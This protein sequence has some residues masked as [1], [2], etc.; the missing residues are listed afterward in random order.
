MNVANSAMNLLLYSRVIKETPEYEA[1]AMEHM[2][3]LLGRNPLSV[4]YITGFGTHAAKKPHHRPS[5]A[6]GSAFA[7]MVV[8]GP[9]ANT[10]RD[11]TL[12]SHCEGSPPSKFY[13][14][15]KDSFASNEVAIYWN[16]VVFFV[17]SVLGM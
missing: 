10:P 3:Y 2:H 13:V 4:S 8:G 9:N 12:N 17:A 14:D 11:E 16:S 1:A 15:H 5:V 7:G 6:E